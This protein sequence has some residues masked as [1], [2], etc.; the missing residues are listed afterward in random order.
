MRGSHY[1]TSPQRG[2]GGAQAKLGRVRGTW[3]FNLDSNLECHCD[4]RMD[5]TQARARTLRK[6]QTDAEAI[7]WSRLRNR[8]MAGRKFRR[9][10]PLLGFVADFASLDAKLIIEL[11]GGQHAEQVEADEKRTRA[12]EAVGFL[13]L[14]FWNEDVF[15]NLESVLETI[16][17]TLKPEEYT[18]V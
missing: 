18:V 7:L 11:D 12:L 6:S 9:Q 15:A 4:C 2:E 14:R 8:Q 3:S 17:A 5:S 1:F 13:V 16:R 10:V